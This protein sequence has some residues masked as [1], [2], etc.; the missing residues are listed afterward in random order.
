MKTREDKDGKQIWEIYTGWAVLV[1][2]CFDF[3]LVQRCVYTGERG[4]ELTMWGMLETWNALLKPFPPKDL[5]L[6]CR[7]K[8]S[9]IVVPR[10][11][12]RTSK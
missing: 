12:N 5:K 11:P 3:H 7:Y 4:G 10:H 9:S 6:K 8:S 2:A 1:A